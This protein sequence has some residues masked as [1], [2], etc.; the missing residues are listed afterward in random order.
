VKELKEVNK[1]DLVMQCLDLHIALS[2]GDSHINGVDFFSELW[3]CR[4]SSLK[5]LILSA[6]QEKIPARNAIRVHKIFR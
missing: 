6:Y 3:C 1:D 4:K 5:V 2:D